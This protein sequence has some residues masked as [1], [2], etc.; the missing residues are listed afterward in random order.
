MHGNFRLGGQTVPVCA[1]HAWE[2][3]RAYKRAHRLANAKADGKEVL[4]PIK[5]L[6]TALAERVRGVVGWIWAQS[7]RL[8][9]PYSV[10]VT[11]PTAAADPFE[12]LLNS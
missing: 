6:K 10:R 9:N 3:E 4:S 5:Q 7:S 1:R 12:E 11:P 8:A 2:R